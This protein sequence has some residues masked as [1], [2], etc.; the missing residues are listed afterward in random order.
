MPN[1]M[2]RKALVIVVLL[3]VVIIASFAMGRTPKKMEVA[4]DDPFAAL[5]FSLEDLNGK[6]HSLE[7]YKDKV[8]FLN[9]WASWCPPCRAEMPSMQKLY[10]SWD[11]K[12]FVMLAVNVRESENKVREFA[13]KN[14]Y[15]FPILLDR[16]GAVADKYK[17]QGIPATYIIRDGGESIVGV[18]GAREWTI[19][20]LQD[21]VQ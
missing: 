1:K 12:Q 10:E 5:G 17:V 8:I 19:E 13:E 15:S 16:D 9:F 18:V 14:G 6:V 20:E 3:V 7:E 11:K 2:Y 4:G 21:V